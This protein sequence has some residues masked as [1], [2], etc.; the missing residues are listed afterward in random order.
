MLEL[1]LVDDALLSDIVE[2]VTTSRT[3]VGFFCFPQNLHCRLQT[4]RVSIGCVR[5]QDRLTLSRRRL[6]ISAFCSSIHH[7]RHRRH[8]H[9]S[10]HPLASQCNK[11]HIQAQ[12]AA[13]N[14]R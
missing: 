9:I 4:S 10:S 12:L 2:S 7:R 1:Q 13:V 14:R 11:Q 8:R 3:Y 5:L 6:G